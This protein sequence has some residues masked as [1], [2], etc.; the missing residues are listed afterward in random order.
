[1]KPRPCRNCGR[2]PSLSPDDDLCDD[3]DGSQEPKAFS[4]YV[5]VTGLD[6]EDIDGG[7]F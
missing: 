2:R 4:G 3:C 6:D 7:E 5:R 1:M